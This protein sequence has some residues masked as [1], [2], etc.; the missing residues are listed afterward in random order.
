MPFL[1]FLFSPQAQKF[2]NGYFINHD[3]LANGKYQTTQLVNKL[4]AN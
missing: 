4:D 3:T 2:R 1:E